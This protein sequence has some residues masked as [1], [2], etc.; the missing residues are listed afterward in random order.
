MN[1]VQQLGP[2]RVLREIG[3]GGMGRVSLAEREGW[4][5]PVVLKRIHSEH[6]ADIRFR[7]RLLR[8]AE[9]AAGLHHLNVV[10]VLETGVID[11]QLYLS[12]E[13]VAGSSLAHVHAASRPELL[14]LAPV[15][16]AIAQACDGLAYVHRFVNPES[17]KWMELIHRDVSLDNLL[18]SFTGTVKIADFG[19]VKTS[20]G[21][22]TT[23]GVVMGKLA[24]MSPE[25]I[26]DE[27]LDARADLYSL[28]VC[29][30]ELL[31]GRRPFPI[32]RGRA[33]MESVLYDA[34]PPLTPLRPGI[35][36][37]LV[38]L[39]EALLAK[40][41]RARPTEATEVAKALR[42]ELATLGESPLFPSRLMEPPVPMPPKPRRAPPGPVP[43][44]APVP[45]PATE[46]MRT[47]AL[48]TRPV[49]R[50]APAPRSESPTQFVGPRVF[51]ARAPEKSWRKWVALSVTGGLLAA[52][53]AWW[54]N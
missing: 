27:P 23:S 43:A 38:S 52:A 24:Y 9:V 48:P 18:L 35:P 28:G 30:Y 5:A 4:D 1:D 2:Y 6:A 14:P 21:T 29:L 11:D 8:E 37:S 13:Y 42:A 12:M 51:T 25:Q 34:P 7:R 39:V 3:E 40:D 19:I 26:R 33:V 31:A 17:G 16:D 46:V 53:A 41:R 15:L 32:Q 20:E 10:R 49:E 44:A 47:E 54:L 22:Q 50:A 45:P 36:A